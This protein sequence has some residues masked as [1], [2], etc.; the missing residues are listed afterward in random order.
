MQ[1][2]QVARGRRDWRDDVLT[3]R[4]V[5][6][7]WELGGGYGHIARLL[8][9]ATE[10]SRRDIR[11]TFVVERM[12][13]FDWPIENDT[14]EES[15]PKDVSLELFLKM[16]GFACVEL[17]V[18]DAPVK[19]DNVLVCFA[20]LILRAG[21]VDTQCAS[22]RIRAFIKL[23]LTQKADAV[24]ADF[25]PMML[26]AAQVADVAVVN[27]GHGFEIPALM[28]TSE[29][30]VNLDVTSYVPWQ[31]KMPDAV[32][33]YTKE[34][35]LAMAR[36]AQTF[37]HYAP[38][39]LHDMYKPDVCALCTW[40]ELDH[41]NRDEQL[42]N[43]VGPIWTEMS[44]K[45]VHWPDNER[46]RVLCY[47]NASFEDVSPLVLALQ[48]LDCEAIIIHP[49][50]NWVVENGV[51]LDSIQYVTYMCALATV[52]DQATLVVCHGGMGMT[53]R[54]LACGKPLILLPLNLEQLLVDRRLVQQRFGLAA[55]IKP[56]CDVITRMLKE[57]L[58]NDVYRQ[59]AQSYSNKYRNMDSSTSVQNVINFLL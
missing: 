51:S 57:I 30:V 14:G 49:G 12:R 34:L 47:L 38:S 32:G 33:F 39:A 10:L 45:Q 46:P 31:P 2:G 37:G 22:L 18:N 20:E 1:T 35:D 17:P 3:M 48:Q 19:S 41:F 50:G 28:R 4:H 53:A 42:S 58:A 59:S 8:P 26:Y 16:Q 7:A 40:P 43:Y 11:V 52:L 15:R 6:I 27:L 5:L 29:G 54:A 13:P 9:I 24:I 55:A 56:D 21:F 36:L 25:S 23:I 44:T